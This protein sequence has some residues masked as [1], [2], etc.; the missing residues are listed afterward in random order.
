VGT[1]NSVDWNWY[2]GESVNIKLDSRAPVG[3]Q[4]LRSYG[5]SGLRGPLLAS[6]GTWQPRTPRARAYYCLDLA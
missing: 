6:L 3:L 4:E 1:G 5:R 2:R